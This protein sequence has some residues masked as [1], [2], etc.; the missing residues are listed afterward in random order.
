MKRMRW[1]A[2]I[3]QHTVVGNRYSAQSNSEVDTEVFG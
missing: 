1:D 2:L 3:N